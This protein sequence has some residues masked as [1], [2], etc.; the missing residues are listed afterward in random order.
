MWYGWVK[1]YKNNN[2]IIYSHSL[3]GVL[4]KEKKYTDLYL[5]PCWMGRRGGKM[6]GNQKGR[7]LGWQMVQKIIYYPN[8]KLEATKHH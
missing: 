8:V 4:E 1:N 3:S 5:G 2:I 7:K 6:L